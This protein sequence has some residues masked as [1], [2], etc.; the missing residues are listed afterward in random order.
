MYTLRFLIGGIKFHAGKDYLKLTPTLASPYSYQRKK[1]ILNIR[2]KTY[3][4]IFFFS[5][6]V[7]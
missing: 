2:F 3:I 6:V 5:L 7:S 4:Q 1:K